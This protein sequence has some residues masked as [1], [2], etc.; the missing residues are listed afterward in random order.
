MTCENCGGVNLY[1]VDSRPVKFGYRRRRE[2]ADCG[3]RTTT[4]EVPEENY[5]A[6]KDCYKIL[7]DIQRWMDKYKIIKEKDSH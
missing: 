1:V 2:C 5:L 6:M 3:L 7:S 4:Y